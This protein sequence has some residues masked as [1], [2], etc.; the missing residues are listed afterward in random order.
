MLDASSRLQTLGLTVLERGWLSSNNVLVMG[1]HG[2]T[3]LIDSGYVGHA[4][5]TLALIQH[6]LGGRPLDLLLNTHLHSDHCGGN[7][8]LQRA[9]P[10]MHT[11]IPPG[12]AQAVR[13]WDEVA[14]TFAPT[15]QRCDR[16]RFDDLLRP[17]DSVQL[18]D[19]RWEVHG[20]PGHDPHAV[21]LFEPSQRVLLSAD[22]LWE[23][24]FGVVFPELEGVHA[25]DEVA[26]T[27]DRIEALNPAVVVPGHGAL[28]TQ[29]DQALAVARQRLAQ[30]AKNPQRHR[31]YAA[32]V[33]IKFRLLDWQRIAHADFMAW[34]QN[35][36][37]LQSLLQ[38]PGAETMALDDLLDEMQRSGALRL[39]DGMVC[40][41]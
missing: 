10:A 41:A 36:P 15:G 29:V 35:T 5:Q 9:F 14:L 25:F 34:V 18:G 11:L 1:R 17:G 21:V 6:R 30:F 3:A 31:R 40:N 32:K 27:L 24:G 4:A 26:A 20:A 7:A 12:L 33:L 37:Y 38:A 19:A 16:F 22:A 8:T 13:V 2:P 23:N 39:W 28:F